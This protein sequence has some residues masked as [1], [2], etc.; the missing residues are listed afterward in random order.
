MTRKLT[1]A[2]PVFISVLAGT[3]VVIP[4][5]SCRRKHI[6]S[7]S[8]GRCVIVEAKTLQLLRWI[9][10]QSL[11]KF[12]CWD[13]PVSS[14]AV[15]WCLYVS[16]CLTGKLVEQLRPLE[17]QCKHFV[18]LIEFALA[19]ERKTRIG[20]K[21]SSPKFFLARAWSFCF[22]LDIRCSHLLSHRWSNKHQRWQHDDQKSH[23]A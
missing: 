7:R 4:S 17:D 11:C 19:M 10:E 22:R 3:S 9:N 14:C 18:H 1:E 12:T 23:P 2:V 20:R 5:L 13:F 8:I 6:A 21:C 15:S 16:Y